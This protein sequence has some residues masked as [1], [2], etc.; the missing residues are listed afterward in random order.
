M[1][2]KRLLPE[3]IQSDYNGIAVRFRKVDDTVYI[4]VTDVSNL[5]MCKYLDWKE[6]Q[7][8]LYSLTKIVFYVNK[9]VMWAIEPSDIER[10]YKI[11]NPSFMADS[12]KSRI[13]WLKNKAQ[14]I[15]SNN[16]TTTNMN[17]IQVFKNSSFGEV[18]VTE[19]N[20]EPYFCLTDICRALDLTNPSMVKQRLSS[21]GVQLIDNHALNSIEGSNTMTNFI[22]EGNL[23]KCIF[24]SRKHNAEQFQDWVCDE[25][26]PSIRKHGAYMT[27]DVIERTLTDP[28]Y[29]IQLATQLKKERQMRLEA[30]EKNKQLS[31]DNTYKAQVIE[32]LTND[33]PLADMRQRIIQ[34]MT[35]GGVSGIRE[36][37]HLLYSEFDKKFHINVAMRM[38]NVMYRGNRMDYIEKELKMLPELYDL[39]CKLF[40]SQYESLIKSWAKTAVRARG[41]RK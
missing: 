16:K 33:I 29:L 20:G 35:K 12:I 6:M 8:N 27:N 11:S 2:I 41:V 18:R 7:L 40:E 39:T 14:E 21:K 17:E 28:D 5:I 25:I 23:Y 22:N 13:E 1:K 26:L 24:Q 37:Y 32:G 4:P 10:L 31:D 15:I 3:I 38:N 30:E 9:G 36:A 19:V 34:I